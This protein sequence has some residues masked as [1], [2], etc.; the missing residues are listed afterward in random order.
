[1]S[2]EWPSVRDD[3]SVTGP[4]HKLPVLRYGER[5]VA[6][7]LVIISFLYRELGDDALLGQDQQLQHQMLISSLYGDVVTPIAVLLY[8]ELMFAGCDFRVVA[9]R[10]FDRLSGQ[11]R[12]IDR[13]LEEWSWCDDM[14][15]RPPMVADCLLY[16]EL[17][18][19][20]EVFGARIDLAALPQL[21]RFDREFAGRAACERVLAAHP[22]CPITARPGEAE[23]AARVRAL[24]EGSS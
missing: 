19:V 14:S 9:T 8:S 5:L 3:R 17:S 16:E 18:V 15:R 13:A 12:A 7:T 23:V 4:F 1:L 2:G 22:G 6:E 24:V 20:R 21:A 10:T 11:L